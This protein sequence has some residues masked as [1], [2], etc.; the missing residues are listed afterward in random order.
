MVRLSH[1]TISIGWESAREQEHLETF[2]LNENLFI[3]S[4]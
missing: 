3:E 2:S 1:R 4:L